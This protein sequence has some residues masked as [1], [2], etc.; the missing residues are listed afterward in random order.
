MT[1]SGEA[2]KEVIIEEARRVLTIEGQS[3][4]A[5]REKLDEDF[6]QIAQVILASKGR[7]VVTGL[8]KSGLVGKKIASTLTSTGTPAY[9]L[10]PSDALHGDAG[11]IVRGDILMAV[12][13]GGETEEIL[14][15]IP[16]ARRQKVPLIAL[17]GNRESRLARECDY[18]LEVRV[19]EEACPLGLAPTA[20]STAT[21][22]MGDALAM[23]LF[24]VRGLKPEDFARLHPAG[25][26]GRRLLLRVKDVLVL[27][28]QNPVLPRT[29]TVDEALLAMTS[30]R[31][32][33]VSIVGQEGKL[34]GIITD[35]DV[36]RSLARE[37]EK[38]L[39]KRVSHIMTEN[40][41]AI[42][43]DLLAVDALRI[44]EEKEIGHLPVVDAD[45]RP[46]GLVNY[47]DLFQM[48]VI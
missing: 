45:G 39:E 30:T 43:E 5:L 27:R 2:R 35:G 20:S 14:D 6:Y 3:V 11:V 32:G 16:L 21:L 48:G 10:H 37:R 36:R 46:V 28:H 8:G 15:L 19:E 29:A 23:A 26:L 38:I 34:E 25:R 44:M 47:Q 17:C 9:F 12:S 1:G 42:T 13:H 4:L 40:P 7:I 41:K 31:M 18:L 24:K 22:A 33:A